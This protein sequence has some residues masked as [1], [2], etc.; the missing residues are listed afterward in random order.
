MSRQQT[1]P[2]EARDPAAAAKEICLRLLTTRS[3]TRAE[4]REALVRKGIGEDTAE[5]VLDRL[6]EVELVDDAAFVEMWVH[7]RHTY[8]GQAR[9]ALL[10]ELRR[11]GV[12][13]SLAR[14]AAGE[15]DS[16]AEEQRARELVEKKLRGAGPPKDERA[17]MRRLVGML[18][19]K[20]YPQG[21]AIRVALEELAD[22]G[23]EAGELDMA[24]EE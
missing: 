19:R 23:V 24:E 10:T 14:D 20:G 6:E 9:R 3:R 22:Y 1:E 12:D 18:A 17:A 15:V 8:S 5:A 4:L 21:L 2:A 7:S 13:D 11:K 16:A